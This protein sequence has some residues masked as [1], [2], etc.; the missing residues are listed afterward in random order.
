VILVRRET[1][2]ADIAGMAVAAGILTTLGGRVSHAAV[3][4]RGWGLP[5]VVGAEQV[6][7]LDGAIRIGERYVPAGTEITIDG[8]SGEVLLGSHRRD[9]VEAPEVAVLRGWRRDAAAGP[10]PARTAG[11]AEDATVQTVSRVLALKGMGDAKTI[12]VVLGAPLVDVAAV[13]DTLLDGK[14]AIAM[15]NGRV[16]PAPGLVER[17]DNWFADAAGRV[18]RQMEAEM[19]A[20]HAVNAAFKALVSDWQMRTVEGRQVVNEHADRDYDAALIARLR[21]E[22]HQVIAPIIVRAAH[23]EPRLIRYLDR[24]ETA[25]EAIDGGDNDM[26][27]YPLKDSYHTVWFELH[28][29]LIRLSGRKRTE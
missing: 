25:L 7:V 21:A 19:E 18:Q 5:A 14:D 10:T 3:V 17:V 29:E 12:A 16:R 4:A 1:S 15:P 24:L 2:P 22:I 28:E 27:A 23:A 13:I 11:H 8:S 20:F 6:E 9:E 26:V